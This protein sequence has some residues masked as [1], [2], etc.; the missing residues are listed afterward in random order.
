MSTISIKQLHAE[1]GRWVRAARLRPITV[2]DHG[3]QVAVIN[4]YSPELIPRPVFSLQ[5]R[6]RPKVLTDSTVF[7]SEDRDR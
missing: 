4:A 5:G 7:I 3:E 1:T 2:T 6:R